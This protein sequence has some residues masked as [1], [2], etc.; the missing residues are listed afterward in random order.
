MP[1]VDLNLD[2]QDQLIESSHLRESS[3]LSRKSCKHLQNRKIVLSGDI[4]CHL[5][6]NSKK[7][8]E[9]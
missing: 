8:V 6:T 3:S 1:G 2:F 4:R 5:F 7:F 9:L